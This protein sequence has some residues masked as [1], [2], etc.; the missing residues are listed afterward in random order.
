MRPPKWSSVTSSH[1][2]LPSSSSL[3]VLNEPVNM[4]DLYCH[5]GASMTLSFLS[6]AFE[7]D[8][9]PD[10]FNA[11]PWRITEGGC[12]EHCSLIRSRR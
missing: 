8:Q 11:F 10:A 6:T 3:S 4:T 9:R 2:S 7:A 5:F 12:D 1:P